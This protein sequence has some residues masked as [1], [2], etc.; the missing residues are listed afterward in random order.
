MTESTTPPWRAMALMGATGTG[1]TALALDVAASCGSVIISCDSMQLY[2]GLDIGTAKA[3]VEERQR[4]RHHL[5]D[6]ADISEV[7]SAQRWADAALE[8]I[9][10][11]NGQGRVPL[12]VGG[13]GM[14][15][16]ALVEGFA[17]IPEEKEGVRDYFVSL[18]AEY[19][20]PYLHDLLKQ[21]DPILAERLHNTDSQRIMRGLCIYK[22][23]NVPLS[24]WQAEQE[25][26]KERIDCPVFVLNVPR[27][28]LRERLAKRIDAMMVAGWLD[29]VRWLKEQQ[30]SELHPAM[31]AVGYRQLLMYLNDECSLQEAL[32][33]AITA[34]RKYAKR[35]VTWFRN[36]TPN[37]VQ[38]DA[39]ALK[40][41]MVEQLKA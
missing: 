6:C 22:S 12:I 11:E 35:Q 23:T 3:S 20:T 4:I 13:T 27:P 21:C 15:L 7:W 14:Y 1:K 40:Q 19:G 26:Q 36:Q 30:V 29:E 18:Q 41:A 5:I 38:G 34:S 16:R 2:C 31:R 32:R 39:E 8:I 33:D 10:Q 17:K 28:E 24:T 37:A 25:A 9:K